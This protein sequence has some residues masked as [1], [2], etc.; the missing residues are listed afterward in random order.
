MPT[1]RSLFAALLAALAG[2]AV[3]HVTLEPAQAAAGGTHKLSF[4]VT[5]GCDG[6]ATTAVVLRLPPGLQ[7]AK[8]MPKPGW[9]LQTTRRPLAQAQER[10][11][12][13]ITDE[14][15]EVRWSGGPL[16]DAHVDE[17]SI[18]AT[19]P[20]GGPAPLAFPLTQECEQGRLDWQDAPGSRAPAPVL[21]L[22][23][24]AGPA[25]HHPH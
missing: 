17:F 13:R 1:L 6:S 20:A 21:R 7:G 14:L 9:S 2:P 24:P 19:L 5:H 25:P 12:R 8:P 23:A 11:G 4:R 15:A 3:A 18:V 10:H 22:Q 16:P